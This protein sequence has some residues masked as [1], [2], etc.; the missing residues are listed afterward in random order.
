MMAKDEGLWGRP[1]QA[2]IDLSAVA[3]N[4]RAFRAAIGP[5]CRIMAVVKA[6][7]YGLGAPWIASAALEGGASM[8][9]V[10][11]VDEGIELRRAGYSGPLLI[12]SYVSPDEA[13]AV[14]R[15]GLTIVL[16]RLPTALALEAAAERA[17][18][19]EGGLPVHIKVDTGLGRFGCLPHEF[20]PLAQG[21][22]RCR[23]LWL[24]GLMTHFADPDG[25]DLAFAREQLARFAEVRRVAA[26]NN[27]AFEIVHAANTAAALMLPESRFDM[28]RTGIA[29]SGHLPAP[30][31]A[32]KVTLRRA[33]TVRTRLARVHHAEVGDSIGYGRT[34][35]A[36]KPSRIGLIPMG[37][38]DGF[39]RALSNLGE[40]LVRGQRCPVVGRISMDQSNIDVTGVPGASEG[41]EVVIIGRQGDEEITADDVA[42]LVR[43]ISY[44]ILC[45]LSERVPRHYIH[46]GEPI[47]VCNLLGCSPTRDR[48]KQKKEMSR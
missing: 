29:L 45:G 48:P 37:Y 26:E 38:A 27:I 24:E 21:V 15:N 9:A 17:G 42:R 23:H 12:M 31:L 22:L 46:G 1:V 6:D 13:E 3:A 40:V 14:V 34:W 43:T 20:L 16:H 10:A 5:R 18:L 19:P 32:E 39:R 35:V 11:C 33:V 25:V 8:L 36:D 4:V 47:E 30:H 28:V 7:G 41:D 44:E 2:E